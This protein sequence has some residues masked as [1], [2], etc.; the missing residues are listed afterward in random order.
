MKKNY[1][2]ELSKQFS[3]KEVSPVEFALETIDKLKRDSLNA[4][5]AFDEE[6]I[7]GDAKAA[8]K[9]YHSGNPLSPLDGI[10]VGVKDNI[11]TKGMQTTYGCEAYRN[12]IPEVDAHVIKSLKAA[13]AITSIKTNLAQFAL[14]HTGENSLNGVV[15]NPHNPE[16]IAGGSSSGSCAAVAAGML[17]AAIGTDS[18]GSVRGPCSL[19]GLVG[20]KPTFSIVS[21]SGIM[22]NSEIMDSVGSISNDVVDNAL[23]LKGIVSYNERDWHSSIAP[24]TGYSSRIGESLANSKIVIISNC[25]EEGAD[26]TIAKGCL[27]I[28]EALK[29]DGV[30]F[31][32]K[33]LPDLSVFQ[34]AHQ[35]CMLAFAHSVHIKDVEDHSEFIDPQILK[36]LQQGDVSSAIY[37][38]YERKKHEL[39]DLLLNIFEDADCLI[40]PTTSRT[41]SKIFDNDISPADAAER[42]RRSYTWISSFSGFPD[43]TI[44]AGK[45]E[46]GLPYGVSLVGRPY[47]EANLYRIGARIMEMNA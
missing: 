8:E 9:R 2:H 29:N 42:M 41:A 19:C 28:I 47:S 22:P 4:I 5:I 14:G 33:R 40:Y 13:G 12:N 36:R 18:G 3:S 37:V 10:P 35:I 17:P 27:D 1:I 24:D 26:P 16:H 21:N 30:T 31:I 32:N 44:P 34:N 43:L 23:L 20:M 6:A 15:K 7:L 45:S 25:F 46:N 39:V 38:E 11:N